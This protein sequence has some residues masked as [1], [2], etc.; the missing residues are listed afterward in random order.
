MPEPAWGLLPGCSKKI[1]AAAP[2][3]FPAPAFQET[4]SLGKSFDGSFPLQ[5]SSLAASGN[6]NLQLHGSSS[7]SA[8]MNSKVNMLWSQGSPSWMPSAD[9][10]ELRNMIEH[11][12]T[13]A[14]KVNDDSMIVSDDTDYP[15]AWK[16]VRNFQVSS[17]RKVASDC[18]EVTFSPTDNY[19]GAINFLPGQSLA[20]KLLNT[21]SYAP[22]N[23]FLTNAPGKDYLQCCISHGDGSF[24]LHDKSS[25]KLNSVV[26]LTAPHG[27]CRTSER[28]VVLI[29]VGAGIAPMKSFLETAPGKVHFV[30]HVDENEAS[31]PFRREFRRSCI[32]N[33]FHYTSKS[34]PF[35]S[36]TLL[37]VLAPRLLEACD[38][39]L[40]GPTTFLETMKNALTT[41]GVKTMHVLTHDSQLAHCGDTSE[42]AL[43]GSP[44]V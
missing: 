1:A 34:G 13:V 6:G 39:V 18:S 20:V 12:A 42:R 14:R 36:E 4:P 35:S 2:F 19:S 3:N 27:A 40:S 31:H 8:G 5:R 10:A 11:Y 28:P 24:G 43:A 26:E 41:A 44:Y 29:S 16:G 9:T 30:V 33:Y 7:A 37:T 25:L 32:G 17:I 22:R 21:D 38:F 23:H 15:V